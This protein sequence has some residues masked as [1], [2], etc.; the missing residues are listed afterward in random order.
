M[1][2]QNACILLIED[3]AAFSA[4]ICDAL[5]DCHQVVPVRTGT[6]AI[7]VAKEQSFDIV[8][9]DYKL[10]DISGDKVCWGIKK[11]AD[12]V[13]PV[14]IFLSG[15]DSLEYRLNAYAAG[16]DDFLAKPFSLRELRVRLSKLLDYRAKHLQA[17]KQVNETQSMVMQTMREAAQYGET[18][19]LVKSTL[20][21]Q[22]EERLAKCFF[23]YMDKLGLHSCIQFRH[24]DYRREYDF[25]GTDC[26][27]IEGNIFNLLNSQGRIY[28]F[29]GRT[30]FNDTHV[31]FLVKNMPVE[32][33]NL[34][35]RFK[36]ILAVAIEAIDARYIELV[37]I[38]TLKAAQEQILTLTNELSA[39]M[40]QLHSR[41]GELTEMIQSELH[42]SFHILELDESQEKYLTDMIAGIVR[43]DQAS[44]KGAKRVR[45]QLGGVVVLLNNCINDAHLNETIAHYEKEEK[46]PFADDDDSVEL[47]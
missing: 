39:N 27:P 43:K 41:G 14:V 22:S 5:S 16:G 40:E 35:G 24:D 15:Y 20:S 3:D 13:Q 47:F 34:F 42:M 28:T 32:N 18:L 30:M 33:E 7:K 46:D 31:S 38:R 25:L 10:P 9:L 29:G 19:H 4:L 11:D 36:D 23:T 12:E 21:C 17:L 1:D 44:Q 45:D 37:R 26:S 6:E 8:L 2:I